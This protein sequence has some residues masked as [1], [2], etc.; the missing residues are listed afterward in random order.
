MTVTPCAFCQPQLDGL[1]Q[2]FRLIH[3]GSMRMEWSIFNATDTVA[4]N[5]RDYHVKVALLRK[6]H[7]REF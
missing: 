4:N 5:R 6:R 7:N 3:K 2:Q 1:C